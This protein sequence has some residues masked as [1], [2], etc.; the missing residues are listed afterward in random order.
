M[1]RYP[2]SDI[3]EQFKME[4]FGQ[5]TFRLSPKSS[6]ELYQEDLERRIRAFRARPDLIRVQ[7][8]RKPSSPKLIQSSLLLPDLECED[9]FGHFDFEKFVNDVLD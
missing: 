6:D 8:G 9:P 4:E 1:Q 5:Q 3:S 2:L 7:L